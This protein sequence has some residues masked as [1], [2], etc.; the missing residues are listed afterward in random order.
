VSDEPIELPM[1]LDEALHFLG[2]GALPGS[3]TAE[4]ARAVVQLHIARLQRETARDAVNW[5]RWSAVA[6]ITSSAIALAAFLFAQF[7]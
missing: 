5:A 2:P 7:A 4:Q 3:Q 6:A 1:S